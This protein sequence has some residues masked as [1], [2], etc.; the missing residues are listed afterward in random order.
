[1]TCVEPHLTIYAYTLWLNVRIVS[2]V[3]LHNEKKNILYA[4]HKNKYAEMDAVKHKLCVMVE[5]CLTCAC[6]LRDDTELK[7]KLLFNFLYTIRLLS[8]K[9]FYS[10]FF[11]VILYILA[12][13]PYKINFLS[14]VSYNTYFTFLVYKII[15]FNT[16]KNRFS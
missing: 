9:R 4:N 3:H 14:K 11:M 7:N 16:S 10:Q 5:L 8:Y 2:Q 12:V 15:Y 13:E 1:M 6:L